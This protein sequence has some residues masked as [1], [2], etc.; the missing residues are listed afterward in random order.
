MAS[1][2]PKRHLEK[3]ILEFATK[4]RELRERLQAPEE[5]AVRDLARILSA[6]EHRD[7]TYTEAELLAIYRRDREKAQEI[8]LK[9]I[10]VESDAEYRASNKKQ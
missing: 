9:R 7:M 5:A 4:N 10:E 6:D 1:D 3:T 2:K 8:G